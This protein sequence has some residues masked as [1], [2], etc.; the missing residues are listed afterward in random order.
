MTP[1]LDMTT[2]R[3]LVATV[4]DYVRERVAPVAAELDRSHEFP[5]Q[6]I[7]EFAEM[8]L[9]GMNIP[10]EFGGLEL[11]LTTRAI[12][13]RELAYSWM[14]LTGILASHSVV[15]GV[16]AK[17]GTAAQKERYLPALA[18][19]EMLGALS[20]TEPHSGSDTKNLLCRAVGTTDGYLIRGRK[21]YVTTGARADLIVLA[22]KTDD[23]KVTCF[24]VDNL[25]EGRARGTIDVSSPFEKLGNR[26][27]EVVEMGYDDHPL[28][29]DAVVGGDDEIGRGLRTVLGQ[30]DIGR[31]N[32]ASMS[33]G[34][35]EAALD[36]AVA[37]AS[38]RTAFGR[39]IDDFQGIEF[40]LADMATSIQAARLLA[41]DVCHRYDAGEDVTMSASMAKLFCSEAAMHVT[42]DAMRIHGGAGYMNDFPVER[43]FRD[44]PLMAIGEGTNEIQKMLIARAVKARG[45][46][47]H[48]S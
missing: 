45:P 48:P 10:E 7:R 37:Y 30:L 25:A 19:G 13:F 34:L 14:S 44:A 41:D 29:A 11:D 35:A 16:I 2:K 42:L 33:V 17:S 23:D 40:M 5:V 26:S 47:G 39:T 21:T 32:I 15:A 20:L 36:A 31:I 6:I 28:P 22:A 9:L 4:R 46:V 38:E 24:I 1:T 12:I 8:G 43:F 27:S 18:S 3:A